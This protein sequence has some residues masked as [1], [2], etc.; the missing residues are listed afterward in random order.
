MLSLSVVS[1]FSSAVSGN[2]HTVL[3]DVPVLVATLYAMPA[4]ATY[5]C[6]V[7]MVNSIL[8]IDC[9]SLKLSVL[10]IGVW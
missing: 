1:A 6:A 2:C 5:K 8:P 3:V 9:G 10:T 7:E 4:P